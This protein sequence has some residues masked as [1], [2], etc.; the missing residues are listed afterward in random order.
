MHYQL[1][2]TDVE[3]EDNHINLLDTLV[4]LNMSRFV[5]LIAECSFTLKR[6]HSNVQ[7]NHFSIL[8][9]IELHDKH[10]ITISANESDLD[11]AIRAIIEKAKR[12]LERTLRSRHPVGAS[13]SASRRP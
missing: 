6:E 5:P 8:C 7:G 11:V 13:K 10:V 3:V 2:T 12:H 4:G 9:S 1:H